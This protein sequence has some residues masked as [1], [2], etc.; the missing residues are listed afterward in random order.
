MNLFKFMVCILIISIIIPVQG[1]TTGKIRGTITDGETGEQLVGVNVVV[2]DLGIGTATDQNG[3]FVIV[4]VPPGS[5]EVSISYIGYTPLTIKEVK[6]NAG[7]STYLNYEMQKGALEGEEVI[8]TAERTAFQRDR[9]HSAAIVGSETVDKMPVT[10]LNEIIQLQSGVVETGGELHF[11][12]GRAREVAYLVDGIPASDNFSQGGGSNL[13]VETSMVQELEVISGTFN[14]EYGSAQS[15]VVNIVTQNVPNEFKAKIRGYI[16]DYASSQNNVYIGV[17]KINP[18]AEKDI[19]FTLSG[20]IIENKLGFFFTNRYNNW[21]SLDWYENRYNSTDG[22]RI[23]AYENWFR[24]HNAGELSETQAIY[25]P[26]SLKTGDYSKGPLREGFSNSF[27]GKLQYRM[28]DN[29]KLTYQAF[30][31]TS[32]TDGAGSSRRYQPDETSTAT[33]LKS[34]HFLTFRHQPLENLFYNLS[35]SYQYN[36][37]DDYY[38]KDNKIAMYPGDTGIQLFDSYSEGFSLGDTPGFYTG[39]YNKNWHKVYL[40][41][42]DI[43]WQ[44]DN[45]NFIKAGFQVK[46][47]KV[48]TYDWGYRS[49]PEWENRKWPTQTN[50]DAADYSFGEYWGLLVNYWQDW[51]A[52]TGSQRYIAV[53]D[54]EY[55]LWR[56]YTISPLKFSFYLQDKMEVGTD[57]IVNAGVRFDAFQPNEQ[58]PVELRTE[59]IN[60]GSEENLEEAEIKYQLSP[61][62]GISFPISANGAFHASYGHFFQMPSYEY[63]FNEPLFVVNR[64]QLEGMTLGNSNLEPEKTTAYEIGI[65]QGLTESIALDVTAYYKNFRN[66]IG[67]ERKNTIDAVG[68]Q[69]YINRDYGYTKGLA[70]E[71]YKNKGRFTGRLAYTLSYTRG[72]ASNP[73]VLYLIQ[74]ATRYG[75][76]QDQFLDRKVLPLDWDQRHV[77]NMYVNYTQPN[78]WSVGLVGFLKSGLPYSPDFVEQFD[79]SEIEYLNQGRQPF[80]WGLDLKAQKFITIGDNFTSVLFVKVDNLFDHLNEID[81]YATSGRAGQNARLPENEELLIEK[82]EQEGHFTLEEVDN[83]PSHYSAPRHVEIGFEVRL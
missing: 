78:N 81:V 53:P 20:P 77:L 35:F 9:T 65:Q 3:N 72:S 46:Q 50:I 23:A 48:N 34:S 6:V 7:R 15:G 31:S 57:I 45:V 10:E 49:T 5:Y 55:T 51:E 14:A 29:T 70:V 33:S 2:S 60:L 42:G 41:K 30:I 75:A 38:R 69:R 47:T 63:M 62:L 76:E 11:R 64:F 39:A 44:V 59:A 61:R 4:N 17:D 83:A 18:L 8:V 67:V 58:Y 32:E 27:T 54:S 13:T 24:R 26:D 68:Y 21:E 52:L 25:I 82:L 28:T 73:N 74:T 36:T 40:A 66:L 56:D 71:V 37:S 22:W 12:G 19:E 1:A 80:N 16:G 79:I 43:S